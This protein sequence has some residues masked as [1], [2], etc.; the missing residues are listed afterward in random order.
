MPGLGAM[1]QSETLRKTEVLHRKT[2]DFMP[3][4]ITVIARIYQK[5]LLLLILLDIQPLFS[6]QLLV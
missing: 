6:H 3:R 2:G 5:M 4:V 1:S